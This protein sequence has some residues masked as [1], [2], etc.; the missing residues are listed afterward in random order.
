MATRFKVQYCSIFIK[1]RFQGHIASENQFPPN[2]VLLN[3]KS[4]TFLKDYLHRK[5]NFERKFQSTNQPL[6][7]K[8]F[9]I[10]SL[11]MYVNSNNTITRS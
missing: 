7:L 10:P 8:S 4:V 9:S 3:S 5:T 1:R 6:I 2:I 11:S